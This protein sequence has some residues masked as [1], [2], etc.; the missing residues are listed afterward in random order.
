MYNEKEMPTNN[1][2]YLFIL[3]IEMLKWYIYNEYLEY[4]QRQCLVSSFTVK[5]MHFN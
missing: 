1:K 5:N 4:I 2:K 3:A